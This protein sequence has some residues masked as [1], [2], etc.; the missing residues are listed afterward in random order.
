MWACVCARI[1]MLRVCWTCRTHKLMDSSMPKS[2]DMTAWMAGMK[3]KDWLVAALQQQPVVKRKPVHKRMSWELMQCSSGV[4]NINERCIEQL[5]KKVEMATKV[6][7]IS[8]AFVPYLSN[9]Q[10]ADFSVLIKIFIKLLA[11][12]SL[13]NLEIRAWKCG[14]RSPYCCCSAIKFSTSIFFFD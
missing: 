3:L 11:I 13:K 12:W 14:P 8:D 10:F 5:Q 1:Y 7:F 4:E 2:A 6:R 9:L